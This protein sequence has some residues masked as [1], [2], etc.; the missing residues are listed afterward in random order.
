MKKSFKAWAVPISWKTGEYPNKSNRV[1]E[2]LYVCGSNETKRE[3]TRLWGKKPVRV[4]V[5]IL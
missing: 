2:R 1:L 4:R 3:A 5:T